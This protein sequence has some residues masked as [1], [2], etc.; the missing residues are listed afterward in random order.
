LITFFGRTQ[1]P[2][3]GKKI[4]KYLR[5][6]CRE[7]QLLEGDTINFVYLSLLEWS[8]W[9]DAHLASSSSQILLLLIAKK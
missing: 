4:R 7:V 1:L 9:N 2:S 5:Q 8:M 3:T 6:K